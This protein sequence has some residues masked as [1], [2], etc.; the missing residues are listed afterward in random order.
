MEVISME[1]FMIDEGLDRAIDI[2]QARIE[3]LKKEH[4]DSLLIEILTDELESLIDEIED[5]KYYKEE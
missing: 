1:R 4:D 3:Y 2:I 5:L